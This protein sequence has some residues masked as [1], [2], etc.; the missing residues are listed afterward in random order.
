MERL[1][2]E[3][4]GSFLT[5]FLKIDIMFE[6][7]LGRAAQNVL[8]PRPRKTKSFR[9]Q[10]EE[11]TPSDETVDIS[12]P[13]L[14]ELD[15]SLT[16]TNAIGRK[17]FRKLK[18]LG[19]GGIGKVYLV[20]TIDIPGM[21]G[22]QFA[23]KVV[24]K[25]SLIHRNK[26]RRILMERNLMATANHPFTCTLYHTF[27]TNTKMYFITQYCAGGELFKL[28]RKQPGRRFNE[29]VVQFYAAEILLVSLTF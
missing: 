8:T 10:Q 7:T 17:N 19:H 21:E 26:V 11:A 27:Q 6:A 4:G 25:A 1:L 24:K 29:D 28:Q 13:A 20:E 14:M 12:S 22:V 5:H 23:M 18:L 9:A 15:A 2:S 16:F 3:Q